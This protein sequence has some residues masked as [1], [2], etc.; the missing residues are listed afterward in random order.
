MKYSM[1]RDLIIFMFFL[2]YLEK[3]PM[4]TVL[5][6]CVQKHTDGVTCFYIM[7]EV[8]IQKFY[9]RNLKFKFCVIFTSLNTI[10][11]E[12]NI[13]NIKHNVCPTLKRFFS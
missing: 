3:Y 11:I 5:A 12:L 6:L 9:N 1:R 4:S 7:R 2:I 10:V 13:K 8:N